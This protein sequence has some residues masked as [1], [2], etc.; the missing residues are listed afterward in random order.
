M[1]NKMRYP[2]LLL[3]LFFC[4]FAQASPSADEAV[5]ATF[6]LTPAGKI[7]AYTSQITQNIE[8]KKDGS[9]AGSKIEIPLASLKTDNGLRDEHM[10]N[11]YLEVAKFPKA[12]LSELKASAGKFDANLTLHGKTSK[13]SGV[14]QV[15]SNKV[16]ASFKVLL[17]SFDIVIP[18]YI[19]VGVENE[20]KVEINIPFK[21]SP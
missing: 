11:K 15:V 12:A 17:S 3:T 6:S 21:K 1:R 5:I 16:K 13:V 19:G 9:F 8:Q 10:K 20:G 2:L 18:K 14:Y 4:V 7:V